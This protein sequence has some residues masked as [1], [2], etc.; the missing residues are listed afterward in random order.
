MRSKGQRSWSQQGQ[1]WSNKHFSRH[2]SPVSR[3]HCDETYRSYS[4]PG[5]RDAVWFPVAV[6]LCPVDPVYFDRMSLEVFKLGFTFVF[7]FCCCSFFVFWLLVWC[8]SNDGA[9][10]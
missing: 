4:L 1:I 3:M 2:F 10:D 5:A 9:W 8:F 6:V 7:G